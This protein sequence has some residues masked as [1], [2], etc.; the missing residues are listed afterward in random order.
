ML[1]RQSA[2]F[3]PTLREDPADAEAVSHKLLV[4][5]GLIRQVG[6]GLWTYLPAGW[7]VHENVVQIVR[8]E[9]NAIGGQEMSMPVLTPAE[10]WQ[11]SGRYDTFDVLMKLR[12]SSE[13]EFVLAATHEE[14]ITFHVSELRSYRDLPKILYHFQTKE[15]DEQR[16]RGGLLRVREFV[17]KDAYSF[18]RDE[19]GLDRSFQA[20]KR[21]YE[22]IFDRCELETVGVQAESGMMGGSESLD[23]LAPSGSGENTLVTCERGDYAADSEIAHGVPRGP[24]FP[25]A[26][27]APEDVETP[28]IATCEDLAGFLGLDLA[29]T[30]KAMPVFANGKVV[31]ALVR[32]DDRL[33]EAKLAA[34][35]GAP[36]RP[37][38]VDEIRQA[39]GAEPG[40]LGPVG[41]GGRIVLDETLRN[42]QFVAGANRTGFHLRGVQ[43]GRDFEA[44]VTDIRLAREG[45]ACPLCGGAL[46]FQT[47]IEVG[48]IF[49]LGT[50]Y[51]VPLGASYLD[52]QSVERPIVMGSYGIGPGRVLAASVEQ[53]HDDRGIAWPASLA[54]Y[55]VHVLSLSGGAVETEEV[56]VTIADDL[57]AA[58]YDVLLDDRDGRPGEKFADADLLGCPVRVT[59]GRRSLD[60]GAVDLRRR[61][62]DADERVPRAS[63]IDWIGQV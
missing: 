20:H 58:G 55:D 10:L 52:E 17:M 57:V 49:K 37:A 56:A 44:E 8:E 11:R 9:M 28:G 4:R 60:D 51:S 3:L 33:D 59:V 23:F 16:P 36:A 47:A 25:D 61:T 46:R 14:T 15:R 27:E 12:D 29:A 43:H 41:F 22:R 6:A 39:F 62:G 7:R 30:S 13:R 31:L 50:F 18:D 21:A 1:Q 32:G 24:S 63:V 38:G 19:E 54:P 45:D 53:R 2:L 26:L 34:A 35:L 40:S 48:H 5:A 42:G